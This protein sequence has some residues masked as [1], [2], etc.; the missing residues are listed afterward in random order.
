MASDGNW[1]PQKWEYQAIN[2]AIFAQT[3]DA[4]KQAM[5]FAD[6]L[7]VQGWEMVNYTVHFHTGKGDTSGYAGTF[8]SS[9]GGSVRQKETVEY[10]NWSAT[11]IFKPCVSG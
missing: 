11:A 5:E 10:K 2:T 4:V 8:G 9:G 7:G 6:N 3:H 1:Y